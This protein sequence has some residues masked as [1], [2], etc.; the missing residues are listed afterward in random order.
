MS[1]PTNSINKIKDTQDVVH[2]IVPHSLTDGNYQVNLPELKSDI[3]VPYN[4][5]QGVSSCYD[6]ST[7]DTAGTWTVSI[8]N[9][10]ELTEG[11]TI[12]IRLKTSYNGTT[13]TLNVNGLGAK[14]VYFKYGNKLTSHYSKESV[15]ALTYTSNAISSGTD[16]S[17]WIIENIYDSTNTFQLRKYYSRYTTK[18]VLYRY[19]ICFVNKDNLLVPA[20]NVNNSTATTKTLTTD[21]FDLSKGIY[22]YNSTTTVAAGKLTGTAILYQQIGL[23]D[24]RYSFNTGTTLVAN[25]PVYL[26]VSRSGTYGEVVL[27]T[28]PI[29]QEIPTTGDGNYYVF[30]GY[31]YDTYRIELTLD[32]PIY[33]YNAKRAAYVTKDFS[34]D[35]NIS[36][37]ATDILDINTSIS[38]LENNKVS[39]SGDTMTGSLTISSGSITAPQYN[40]AHNWP[41]I[42]VIDDS[43]TQISNSYTSTRI[44][45]DTQPEWWLMGSS[46]GVLALTKD[47]PTALKNPNALTIGDKTYDGSA[48]VTIDLATGDANGQVKIA[49][50]NVDV[51]GLGSA[52]YTD[53]S[54]YAA[55]SALNNYLPLTA[56]SRKPLT[57][58]LVLNGKPIIRGNGS[59]NL[60][61][62]GSNNI[63]S[64]LGDQ[65]IIFDNKYTDPSDG[66]ERSG[67]YRLP[68]ND[69]SLE[70]RRYTIATQ[71]WA[72]NSL[73]IQ[74]SNGLTQVND[75]ETLSGRVHIKILSGNAH[76][77]IS[78]ANK[79]GL[80]DIG[81]KG[82]GNP[83]AIY[84]PNGD[85][86]EITANAQTGVLY[87][88][89]ID[90]DVASGWY[91]MNGSTDIEVYGEAPVSLNLQESFDRVNQV[92]TSAI[93]TVTWTASAGELNFKNSAGT[94]KSTVTL[95]I[96][97]YGGT[98]YGE[99][100]TINA[101]NLEYSMQIGES[102]FTVD[103]EVPGDDRASNMLQVSNSTF[104]YKGNNVLHTGNIKTINNQSL[105]GSGNLTVTASMPTEA[106]KI[107]SSG[108]T[109]IDIQRYGGSNYRL[110]IRSGTASVKGQ[111]MNTINLNVTLPNTSYMVILTE[112]TNVS[113]NAY[114]PI[115]RGKT[116]S[117]FLLYLSTSGT[118]SYDYMVICMV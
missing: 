92:A 80:Y 8:P 60:T 45:S 78:D 18:S 72:Q 75:G 114:I 90:L 35:T 51:K 9:I 71:E 53:S 61:N 104:T 38:N 62:Y 82:I 65:G 83:I 1:K 84:T 7:T 81:C 101:P 12:K 117:T 87:D 70:S 116:E 67:F 22:Y 55:A 50:T 115:V 5:L 73:P 39:K 6:T 2:E 16:R 94:I 89:G 32:H 86:I 4:T 49:G 21:S 95:P 47:I 30:L 96:K 17:G 111:T 25:K 68:T 79:T 52:A 77:E 36:K 27:A 10:T 113:R 14:T 88:T 26:V 76:C 19:M 103:M 44:Y 106:A 13:N 110:I 102:G 28:N 3:V 48:A 109:N 59:L 100:Y 29:A 64:L 42:K 24:L 112:R 118:F 20:N 99:C 58:M 91:L 31:A 34:Q 11:L 56:G 98:T 69:G 97:Y 43:V 63:I 85:T 54:T 23:L 37:N 57:G 46:Q 15:L 74:F 107:V 41:V 33:V 108:T 66:A 93:A 105:V 40:D